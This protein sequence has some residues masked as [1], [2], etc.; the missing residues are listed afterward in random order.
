[1]AEESAQKRKRKWNYNQTTINEEDM[2]PGQRGFMATCN[3]SEKRCLWDCMKLLTDYADELFGEESAEKDK[4]GKTKEDDTAEPKG[5]ENSPLKKLK[6]DDII[7]EL[8]KVSEAE[9]KLMKSGSKRFQVGSS[10]ILN[11]V[12]IRTN[13]EEP[14][15]F[16][17]HIVKDV[18]EKKQKKWRH[19]LRMIPVDAICRCTIDE[20]TK[21][22]EVVA[23]KYFTEAVTYGIIVVRKKNNTVNKEEII[24][25]LAGIIN[26]KNNKNRVDLDNPERTLIVNVIKGLCCLSVVMNYKQYKKYNLAELIDS[27]EEETS[28]DKKEDAS[29]NAESESKESENNVTKE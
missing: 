1:M 10:G 29:K 6:E 3:F 26:S 18:A 19:I 15:K 28:T 21:T 24:K 12:F 8:E 5:E 11:C 20:I 14:A 4:D 23:E 7:D 22:G 27:R 16:V 17:H 9:Q 13:L 25:C 2:A